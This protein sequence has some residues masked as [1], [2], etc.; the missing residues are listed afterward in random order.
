MEGLLVVVVAVNEPTIRQNNKSKYSSTFKVDI[1][2]KRSEIK[3]EKCLLTD[4]PVVCFH[5]ASH[6]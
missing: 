6:G 2:S 1:H 3:M 5:T 4:I